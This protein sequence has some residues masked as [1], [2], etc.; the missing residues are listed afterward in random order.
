MANVHKPVSCSGSL[1]LI[2]VAV[3]KEILTKRSTFLIAGTLSDAGES[4]KTIVAVPE[5]QSCLPP[6]GM[7]QLC[8]KR[9]PYCFDAEVLLLPVAA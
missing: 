7:C 6:S 9:C 4:F 1:S 2:K 3:Y 5:L 8:V